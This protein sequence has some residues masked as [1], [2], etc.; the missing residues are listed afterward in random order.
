MKMCPH[1]FTNDVCDFLHTLEGHTDTDQDFILAVR[2]EA[3][4]KIGK[5]TSLKILGVNSNQKISWND[6]KPYMN[7]LVWKLD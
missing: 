3:A 2:M 7:K 4:L 1:L 5:H 6:F